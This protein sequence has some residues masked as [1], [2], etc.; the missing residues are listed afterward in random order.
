MAVGLNDLEVVA[1]QVPPLPDSAPAVVNAGSLRPVAHVTS[2]WLAYG[3]KRE[4]STT[5]PDCGE[6]AVPVSVAVSPSLVRPRLPPPVAL[7]CVVMAGLAVEM[8]TSSLASGQVDVF[9][10]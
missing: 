3:P 2:L 7:I 9:P 8:A 5:S 1:V 10:L 6:P 4:K